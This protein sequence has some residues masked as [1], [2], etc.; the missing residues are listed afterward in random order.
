M[1]N[2]SARSYALPLVYVWYKSEAYGHIFTI[3]IITGKRAPFEWQ[4]SLEDSAKFVLWIR[5][6][7]YTSSLA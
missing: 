1:F 3:V 5:A 4:I 7:I 2:C 6:S